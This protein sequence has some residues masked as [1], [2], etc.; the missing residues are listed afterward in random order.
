MAVRTAAADKRSHDGHG[1]YDRYDRHRRGTGEPLC[2]AVFAG[3]AAVTAWTAGR[4]PLRVWA[5]YAVAAYVFGAVLCLFPRSRRIGRAGPVAGAT[6]VPCADMVARGVELSEIGVIEEAAA[7]LLSTGT[8][9]L[10]PVELA[11]QG[12]Q[13]YNPYLPG[14]ALFGLPR[15]LGGAESLWGDPRWYF[16]AAFAVVLSVAL[17]LAGM[18]RRRTALPVGVLAACPLAAM[19]LTGGGDDLPVI[20]LCCLGLALAARGRAGR[21]GLAI[22]V[23]AAL[24]ATAWPAAAV[25]LALACARSES[26]GVRGA[27]RYVAGAAA[28][29]LLGVGLPGLVDPAGLIENTVRFP[30]GLTPVVSPAD[31][32]MLGNLLA[33]TG[34]VGRTLALV[35]L[36]L[37][38]LGMAVSLV[39]RPPA[40]GP[41]AALRLAIGLTVAMVLMPA[42]RWG[43]L[44]YPLVL[45]AW[46]RLAAR[47]AARDDGAPDDG[48]PDDGAPDDGAPDDGAP[49]DGVRDDGAPDDGVRDDGARYGGDQGGDGGRPGA[50]G[51]EPVRQNLKPRHISSFT[52][53][54]CVTGDVMV[55]W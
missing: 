51:C 37:S 18:A 35:L 24:K 23:A 49:D 44:V 42:T 33:G 4:E 22:G 30:L 34:P 21:A 48:A 17:T 31:S 11:G 8:P 28:P 38:A 10:S 29:V 14:M 20:A 16:A 50:D 39:V 36:A 46:G 32:P 26:R 40:D 3:F 25:C 2:Y 43:Y 1:G 27:A 19:P 6:L 12:Y 53:D 41:A 13:S 7:R 47:C 15:A 52:V 54:S 9:Y 45:L 55:R 5:G